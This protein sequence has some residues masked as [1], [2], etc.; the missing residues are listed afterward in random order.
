ML[1]CQPL[2][3]G[4]LVCQWCTELPGGGSTVTHKEQPGSREAADEIEQ[5]Q[6]E[7]GQ[8][9]DE[10]KNGHKLHPLLACP[11]THART[12]KRDETEH[13]QQEHQY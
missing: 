6:Y 8:S 11:V 3:S 1:D 12:D 2:Q 13:L 5:V 4:A 9:G 7:V 10:G